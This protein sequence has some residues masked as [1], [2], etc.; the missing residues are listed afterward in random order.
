MGEYGRLKE[1]KAQL[2]LQLTQ[3]EFFYNHIDQRKGVAVAGVVG[4]ILILIVLLLVV[5]YITCESAFAMVVVPVMVVGWFVWLGITVKTIGLDI[6]N[7]IHGEFEK[8][9]MESLKKQE[10]L[11]RAIVEINQQMR[12]IPVNLWT[13]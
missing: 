6:K 11:R 3:E 2:E 8:E 13:S 10:K 4:N 1:E 12:K 9:K 7:L 5:F